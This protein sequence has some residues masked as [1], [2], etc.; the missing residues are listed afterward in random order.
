MKVL[1][2]TYQ[3]AFFCPGGGEQQFL[4]TYEALKNCGYDV[5]LFDYHDSETIKDSNIIHVFSVCYGLEAL[6]NAAKKAKKKIVVSPIHWPKGIERDSQEYNRIRHILLQADIIM[7]NS[8]TEANY[9]NQFYC[10][11]K[12]ERFNPV[13]NGL[14]RFYLENAFSHKRLNKEKEHIKVL[15]CGNIEERKNIEKLAEATKYLGYKLTLAGRIRSQ[16][17]L[18][19][20]KS[21]G[22]D[23][24]LINGYKNE[25]IDH[26]N[27]MDEHDIFC[28]PSHY[29]T[30]GLAALEACIYGMKTVITKEGCTQEYFKNSA[31][32][33]DP[34]TTDSIIKALKAAE[35]NGR[36]KLESNGLEDLYTW[37]NAALQTIEGY[38]KIS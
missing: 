1:L 18:D 2:A 10:L 8:I 9:L 34:Q 32:Y 35:I 21:K 24:T 29:E 20:I 25:S 16:S 19:K 28:L 37:E 22:N 36:S 7:P 13:C 23:F 12:I 27:L 38:Q 15:F 4:K 6:I 14:S 30:P 31:F 3:S 17:I 5:E 33:C 11:D 26:L